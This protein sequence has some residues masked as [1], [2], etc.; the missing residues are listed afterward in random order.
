M[1][2]SDLISLNGK[3]SL[4]PVEFNTAPPEIEWLANIT[5]VK[6][7]RVYEVDVAEFTTFGASGSCCAAHCHAPTSS[8]GARTWKLV[9][10]RWPACAESSWLFPRVGVSL[11]AQR[12]LGRSNGWRRAAMALS[13]EVGTPPLGDAQAR[14]LLDASLADTL[15]WSAIARFSPPCGIRRKEL[16]LLRLRDIQSREAVP[17]FHVRGKAHQNPFHSRSPNGAAAHW[18]VSG[19]AKTRRG[20]IDENLDSA[21][22]QPVQNNALTFSRSPSIWGRSIA[23]PSASMA[24]RRA[25]MLR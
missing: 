7:R 24:V 20:L 9:S 12:G 25:F 22:F 23:I 11:L 19:S 3:E 16:S 13:S 18:R 8:P 10:S 21:L 14:R 1:S 5:N 17:H 2:T 4:N 15:K 6:T